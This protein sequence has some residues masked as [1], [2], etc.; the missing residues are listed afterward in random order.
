MM[1]LLA[2]AGSYESLV[3]AVN[4]GADAVYMGGP[5]F[6]ARA[7]ADNPDTDRFIDGITY[8]H[9]YGAKVYMTVNTLFKPDEISELAE[10]IRP[11]YCA[12][13]D[14]V[15]VQDLGALKILRE[16]YPKL[17]IHASTQMTVANVYSA[18]LLKELGLTRVVPARELS[19]AEIKK[20]RDEVGIEVETF[21]H[22]ALCYCYSGQCL[23]SSLIGGRSGNRGRCAQ[24]CRLE[25]S[26]K[27]YDEPFT[28]LSLKDLCS[29]D[30]LP[31]L[32]AAGI[33]SL[34][35]EGRMK[36]P[37]YTAGVTE[38]WRKYIDLLERE[39]A[40]NYRVNPKDKKM[41]SDLF[42]R[43]GFT[44][45]YYFEHNGQDMMAWNERR[46]R[47]GQNEELYSYLDEKYVNVIRKLQIKGAITIRQDRSIQLS[48]IAS[49]HKP[50]AVKA[51]KPDKAINRAL[52]EDDI[53]KQMEKTGGTIFEW[54]ELTVDT[55]GESFVP[56]GALNEMRRTVLTALQKEIDNE[57]K[58]TL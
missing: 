32:A 14:A 43:G 15:L 9:R 3:A 46:D 30:I 1:E 54:E 28:L 4:A 7:Y 49:G 50:C 42:D 17:E 24:P 11:Y 19:L 20:I 5:R 10:Y 44:D 45:G 51:G 2:P 25:Y 40:E 37:R 22:G 53:R 6:G 55:D 36:S 29:I 16:T 52:T 56:M 33:D 39:G 8:A 57:S 34:K 58:R 35:I 12:G 18:K 27:G 21:I 26:V 41:L 47:F 38:V 23:M 13:V 31:Q 48:A